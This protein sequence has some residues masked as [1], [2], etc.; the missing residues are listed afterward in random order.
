MV[1]TPVPLEP[2]EWVPLFLRYL[3]NEKG[4]SS[5]TVRNY[6]QALREFSGAHQGKSWAKLGLADFRQH[7][8]DLSIQCKL[9][10]ASIRLRFAALR[11]FYRFLIKRELIQTNPFE[12][13]KMPP[14]EKRLPKF[15][16]EEQLQRFLAAPHEAQKQNPKKRGRPMQKWQT[17]RDAALLEVL[18][19]T[20][21]RLSEIA[22]MQWSDVDFRTGGVRVVGKGKKERVTILGKPA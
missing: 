13:L 4:D 22:A 2:K 9:H 15:L 6:T 12:G 5:Y 1:K 20:G 17:E 10:P 14:L 8:Y 7:L 11:S 3:K 21:M 18:Y 19:S 16:T